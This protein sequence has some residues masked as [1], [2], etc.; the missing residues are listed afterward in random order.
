LWR[1]ISDQIQEGRTHDA[2]GDTYWSLGQPAKAKENF[3][4]ALTLAKSSKDRTGEASASSNL[5]LK[6]IL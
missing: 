2:I 3:T 5:G 4:Q 1:S 6:G